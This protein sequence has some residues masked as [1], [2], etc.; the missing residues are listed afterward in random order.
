[1]Y[2]SSLLPDF[3]QL[4]PD[5]VN[6]LQNVAHLLQDSRGRVRFQ[7]CCGRALSEGLGERRHVVHPVVYPV[8]VDIEVAVNKYPGAFPG[9]A[10]LVQEG[11]Q[12]QFGLFQTQQGS[13]LPVD[14]TQD[15]GSQGGAAAADA[16]VAEV[17]PH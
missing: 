3:V 15:E 4:L 5:L 2:L 12:T 7:A 9:F 10:D 13:P 11:L 16:V 14:S 1:L 8:Q 6:L 17:H